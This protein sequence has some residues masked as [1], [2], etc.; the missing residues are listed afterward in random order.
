MRET[1]Q[2]DNHLG[3]IGWLGGYAGEATAK[4]TT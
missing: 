3:V 1:K 2:F 4:A